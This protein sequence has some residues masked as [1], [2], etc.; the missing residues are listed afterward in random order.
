MESI[1]RLEDYQRQLDSESAVLV[2]FSHERCNVCK[3]LKPK[4]A[5]LLH[6]NFPKIKQ[7]YCNTELSPEIA[8]AHSVFAVPTLL[9]Y[10]EGRE[11]FRFSRNIGLGELEAALE[12]P[13]KLYFQP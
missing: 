3:V 9:I 6:Q 12:R 4:V 7:L 13:Y 11:T 2:Y 8:G 5:E 10:F 1:T